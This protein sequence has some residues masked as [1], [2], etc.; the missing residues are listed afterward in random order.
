M[1]PSRPRRDAT[2][3]S[4][5]LRSPWPHRE[6]VGRGPR[7]EV[8]RPAFQV[9]KAVVASAVNDEGEQIHP[10]K[11]NDEF[12]GLPVVDP[13]KQHRP[14]VSRAELEPILAA[15][16]PKYASLVALLAVTGVRIGEALGLRASDFGPES[17]V[18]HVRRSIWHGKEQEPKTR[19]AIRQVDVPERFAAVLR[20]LVEG[21]TGY[22]FATRSGNALGQRNVLRALHAA[23]AK[24]GFHAL[25]DS[26]R[27]PFG[28]PRH[29]RTSFASGSATRPAASLTT[30]PA[31]CEMT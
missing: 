27:R 11:W 9:A 28:A 8:H 16:T 2:I 10:R 7:A 17:R 23:G 20:G 26:E 14:T 1:D 19:N 3:G 21:K 25:G 13:T 22:L 18:L 12:V 5:E 15:L 24:F 4:W 31:V 6:D 29:R 30:T